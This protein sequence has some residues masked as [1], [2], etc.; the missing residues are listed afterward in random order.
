MN[1]NTKRILMSFMI[2]MKIS[3]QILSKNTLVIGIVTLDVSKKLH[4]PKTNYMFTSYA[5]WLEQNN[6]EWIPITLNDSP[7]TLFEKLEKIN[8]IFLTGGSQDLIDKNGFPTN[9]KQILATVVNYAKIKNIKGTVFPILGTCL[10]FQSLLNIL[11]NN[12]L[13]LVRASNENETRKVDITKEGYKSNLNLI[14]SQE[15][16]KNFS[17]EPLFYYHH[18]WGYLKEDTDSSEIFK[19]NI[20]PLGYNLDDKGREIL[21]IFEDKKYPF[22]GWQFHPE[23]IQFEHNDNFIINKSEKSIDFNSRFSKL[24]LKFLKDEKAKINFKEIKAYRKN[25]YTKFSYNSND[26]SFFFPYVEENTAIE[27]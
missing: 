27:E 22:I 9:Y 18:S 23:K 16:L 15:D 26:E 13:A 10:G 20:N 7:S 19:A 6:L 5:K 25:I 11:T 17:E 2:F 14:F 12:N 4:L 24:F 3:T 1:I 21:A 8:G